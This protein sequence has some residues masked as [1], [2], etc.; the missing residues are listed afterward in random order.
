MRRLL[1]VLTAM[2]LI[3]PSTDANTVGARNRSSDVVTAG[4][5]GV[6]NDG[7]VNSDLEMGN[8]PY[9]IDGGTNGLA[10][11]PDNDSDNDVIIV[12][13]GSDIGDIVA[14]APDGSVIQM[15]AGT[16]SECDIDIT[17]KSISLFGAGVSDTIISCT[18]S[19][20]NTPIIHITALTSTDYVRLSGFSIT[21]TSSSSGTTGF[22]GI[23]SDQIAGECLD[24][25]HLI[26]E[27]M[28]IDI[29]ATNTEFPFAINTKD[30]SPTIRN[31]YAKVDAD[32]VNSSA[33]AVA[34]Y[35][36][37]TCELATQTVNLYNSRFYSQS[38]TTSS[39]QNSRP[40]MLWGSNSA[41]TAT[42][43]TYNLY[44]VHTLAEATSASAE[45]LGIYLVND[46]TDSSSSSTANIYGGTYRAASDGGRML[47]CTSTASAKVNFNFYGTTLEAKQGQANIYSID[48]D[49]TL[50]ASGYFQGSAMILR[51]YITPNDTTSSA[52]G[53][54]GLDLLDATGTTGGSTA[55]TGSS[56]TGGE[57][58]DVLF[59]LG[60]GGFSLN[61][62]VTETGGSGGDG[63][64][65]AGTGQVATRAV[66]T[67]NGGA[68][69]YWQFIAGQG[70]NASGATTTNG[71]AGGYFEFIGGAGGSATTAGAGG[72]IL[73]R[74]GTS[75]VGGTPSPGTTTLAG[76]HA[77]PGNTNNNGGDV[78]LEPGAATGS[79]SAKTKIYSTISGASGTTVRNPTLTLEV[80][81][82]HLE[83]LNTSPSVESCGTSPTVSG[84]DISG[85]ITAGTASPTSCKLTFA[86]A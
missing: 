82:G 5:G 72:S 10:L 19:T 28:D 63:V 85:I 75:G 26:I 34:I 65:V 25:G 21:G 77:G 81:Q 15:T 60:P 68:G 32:G 50:N 56:T 22:W 39:S 71:G 30:I 24:E 84:T 29:S 69:G 27:N 37:G 51:K 2:F 64:F 45:S 42:D 18:T 78:V 57:G 73:F 47:R 4:G 6:S 44:D 80:L 35:T 43:T 11:N 61:S 40:L 66:T 55:N 46:S 38:D 59:T 52:I 79:G 53:L 31:V 13:P 70:G 36:Q 83:S 7:T 54:D 20:T 41:A 33:R 23:F 86:N 8:T 1:L 49:C 76:G 67:G 16:W 58:A 17:G 3:A 62:T 12:S 74:A 14:N 48:A 9:S